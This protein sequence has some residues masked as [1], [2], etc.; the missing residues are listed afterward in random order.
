[1]EAVWRILANSEVANGF[2]HVFSGDVS[3][4]KVDAIGRFLAD[5]SY[6]CGRRCSPAYEE[7]TPQRLHDPQEAMLITDTV[8]DVEEAVAARIPVG[9]RSWGMHPADD[10]QA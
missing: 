5:P 6:S 9:A 1:M 4:S 8:G 2:P 10:R 3:P 7:S